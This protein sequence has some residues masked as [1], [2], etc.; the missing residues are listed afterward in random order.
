[1]HDAVKA[2]GIGAPVMR[3]EDARF[4]TGG[5]S[6]VDDLSL[7]NMA[8]AAVV[9]SPHA[10]ARIKS[11]DTEAAKAAPGVLLVLTGEDVKRSGIGGLP[12]RSYPPMAKRK[13]GF[14]P[15]HPILVSDKARHVGDRVA[16]VVA[17]T[18]AQAKDAAELVEVDYEPLE[19]VSMG[20]A[21]L[22]SGAP[23]VWD[24]TPDNLCFEIASGD[25]AAVERV[26]AQA[27]HVTRLEF[28][29]PRASANAIE[30][31]ATLGAY[32]RFR[33]R[34]TLY[35][36]AQAPHRV[37][38]ILAAC[39]LRVPETD[40]RVVSP[41]VGGGFGTKGANYPEE[42]LVVWAAGM[43]DRP[44]KWTADRSESLASDLHG[45]D[46]IDMAELALDAN[47]KMLALRV[48]ATLNVGAYLAFSAGVPGM[49]TLHCWTTVYDLPL[50]H[51][52]VRAAY[53]NTNPVGPYRGSGRPEC[54]LIMERIADKAAREM[55]IDPR[56]AA[57]AQH[58][59]ARAHAVQDGGRADL[60]LRR[61]RRRARS[62][63]DP[64]RCERA[65]RRA[66]PRAN[67][68]GEARARRRGA[69]RIRRAV[70]RAHGDPRRSRRRGLR[71]CRHARH[72]PGPR[73]DVRADGVRLARLAAR[74]RARVP[75]R[76]RPRAV[77]A[78]HLRRAQRHG[79]RLGAQGRGR[80]RDRQGQEAR[81]RDAGSGRHR[82]RVR[83]RRVP[84]RRHRPRR[85]LRRR[86]ALRA[87]A[88]GRADR[89]RHRARRHRRL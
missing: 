23:K 9:R 71:P 19:A 38:E 45:R 57:A 46:Q 85:A 15:T 4:L 59:P 3:V 62:R 16:F 1:M 37:R 53:S 69:R 8:Y 35:T 49:I 2:G 26:F 64:G 56:R 76:H 44:V 83:R 22:A 48:T 82:H 7:P 58:D 68:A 67:D 54:T 24:E 89:A 87:R 65:S 6:Y 63:A 29:Y 55:G 72:R 81:R 40:L 50:V 88:D 73:D 31:R 39:V 28:H 70:Q 41:D 75:G 86:R 18:A 27:A 47:G 78:R 60:R 42:A 12:C 36:E 20:V 43:L 61:F 13:P 11:I 21:A 66:A 5:G 34:Y 74:P 80:R 30:P 17:E 14:V 51:A 52:T 33:N 77:R 32:D 10:H 84:R 79:R 25:A